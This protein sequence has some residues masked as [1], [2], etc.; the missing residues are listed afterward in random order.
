[1]RTFLLSALLISATALSAS[2]YY[3]LEWVKRVDQNLYSAK[4]GMTKVLI[5][6]RFC[7]EMT[8]GSDAT[9]K[10]DRYGY[11]NKIIFEDHAVCDV[12]KVVA[13]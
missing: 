9:L 10:Y 11:D 12:V 1:M 6:T 8:I 7:T 4:S 5:E 2:D 13:E 3:K